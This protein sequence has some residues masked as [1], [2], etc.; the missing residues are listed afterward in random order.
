[1]RD[2]NNRAV[3]PGPHH[4]IGVT[5]TPCRTRTIGYICRWNAYFEQPLAIGELLWI[6]VPE[7]TALIVQAGADE[8]VPFSP[9]P[10]AAVG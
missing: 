2:A 3:G 8:Q 6:E 10:L 1:V 5:R 4:P 7:S 9:Q